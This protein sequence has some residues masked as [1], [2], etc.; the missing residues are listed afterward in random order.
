VPNV[1]LLLLVLAGLAAALPVGAAVFTPTTTVDTF[2]G[3]C[4]AHCSLREAVAAANAAP[5]PDEVR[6]PAGVYPLTRAGAG[7]DA[8]A[9][10]DLDVTSDLRILGAGA[11]GTVI[12]GLGLDRILQVQAPFPNEAVV[13]IADLTL[14]NG[15]ARTTASGDG[16][17][18]AIVNYG[19]T[20]KVLRCHL[21]GNV[22]EQGGGIFNLGLL[23]V[24]DS[25]ISGNTAQILGGGLV[26]DLGSFDLFNVTISGNAAMEGIGGG[27][28]GIGA[29]PI[30]LIE[31]STI[32]GNTAP[33]H[34]GIYAEPLAPEVS[35]PVFPVLRNSLVAGNSSSQVPECGL[36]LDAAHNLIARTTD[37]Q[38]TLPVPL[39]LGPLA[40]NGGPTP[41]HA[42]LP[43]SPAIDAGPAAAGTAGCAAQDQRG[44]PRPADGDGNGVSRCDVGDFEKL[45][46]TLPC[47][48]DDTTLC[49]GGRFRVTAEWTRPDGQTGAAHAVTLTPDAGYYW[50]FDSANVEVIVKSIDACAPFDHFWIFL[51]GLTNVDVEVRVEDTH[52]GTTKTYH[53]PQS[54]PFAPIYDTETFATCP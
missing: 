9:T 36:D 12:D 26:T 27:I 49:L 2:D 13:E 53:N 51:A 47:T 18:G 22:A 34:G 1:R 50:F 32:T 37:C 7:E 39:G 42:L 24:R 5:G 31:S 40:D 20:V 6:V 43:G 46:G 33:F 10:G 4:D 11:D 21:D 28:F 14:R 15:N 8:S 38:V 3:A 23:E 54:T 52:S 30:G 17:G 16:L 41:T 19:H 45:D 29:G 48:S 44:R 35:L 25:T